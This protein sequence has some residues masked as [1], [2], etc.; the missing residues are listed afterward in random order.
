LGVWPITTDSHSAGD[1]VTVLIRP[2]AAS[3]E[4][5]GGIPLEGEIV[6]TLFRGRFYQL[7]LAAGGQ[8]LTF[9]LP[10]VSLPP[11]GSRLTLWLDPDAISVLENG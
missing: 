1:T 8:R 9:E 3:L 10:S 6:A 5:N 2:E 7:T 11:A 4:S